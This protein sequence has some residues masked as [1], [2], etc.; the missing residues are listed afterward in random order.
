MREESCAE[1]PRRGAARD[2]ADRFRRRRRGLETRC[3]GAGRAR[4]LPG[5]PR[6]DSRGCR[7]PARRCGLAPAADLRARLRDPP[8]REHAGGGAH[9]GVGRLRR[10]VRLL[11]LPLP[12]PRPG[13]DPGALHRPRQRLPGRL[14]RCR[15]RHLRRPAPR[16]RVLRQPARR[17]DGPGA[18]RRQ[19]G[20]GRDL[21]RDLG[22]GRPDHRR[23]LRGRGGD[24]VLVA[25]L[26]RRRRASDLGHRRGPHLAARRPRPARAR[27]ARARP[28]LLPLPGGAARGAGGGAP[29][30]RPRGDPD[31]DRQP[32]GRHAIPSPRRRSP[33]ATRRPSSV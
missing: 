23:G 17:P 7:R 16:L 14:R 11:R 29:G 32:L 2:P 1:R 3:R 10:R 30:P 19:L 5:A 8:R 33:R 27:A 18:G 20:R 4:P 22:L 6:G 28:E 9:R 13:A 15:P 24:P 21:G 25:A 12:G 31:P 26:R